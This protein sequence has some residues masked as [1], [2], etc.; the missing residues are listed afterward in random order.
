MSQLWTRCPNLGHTLF[1]IQH[2]MKLFIKFIKFTC[3]L[4]FT[5]MNKGQPCSAEKKRRRR[6]V[7]IGKNGGTTMVGVLK[8]KLLYLAKLLAACPTDSN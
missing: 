2:Y 6:N 5:S 4:C 7:I 3:V 1:N 8:K